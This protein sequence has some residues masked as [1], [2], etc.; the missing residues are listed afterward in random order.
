MKKTVD[1]LVFNTLNEQNRIKIKESTGIENRLYGEWNQRLKYYKDQKFKTKMRTIY[2]Q[3]I[4][5]KINNYS[6]KD[7]HNSFEK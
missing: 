5:P 7:I 1:I 2:S 3:E 6:I 4:L